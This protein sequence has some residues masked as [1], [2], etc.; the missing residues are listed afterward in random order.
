MIRS[1][2]A[3]ILCAAAL[4]C[5]REP[6]PPSGHLEMADRD[7]EA[8]VSAFVLQFPALSLTFADGSPEAKK[9]ADAAILVSPYDRES[10]AFGLTVRAPGKIGG[11]EKIRPL[12]PF[13][14]AGTRRSPTIPLA[15]NWYAL[16]Y[17]EENRQKAGIEIPADW[18]SL[19]VTSEKIKETGSVPVAL[20]AA[21]GRTLSYWYSYADM[22]LNGARSYRERLEGKR[23]YDDA[24]SVKALALV[25]EM[26]RSGVFSTGA[27]RKTPDEAWL[28]LLEGRAVF[29]LSDSSALDRIPP[30]RDIRCVAVP[31]KGSKKF[32]D[33]G[34]LSRTSSIALLSEKAEAASFVRAF[35]LAGA[36]GMTDGKKIIAAFADYSTISAKANPGPSILDAAVEVSPPLDQS[37]PPQFAYDS[38]RLFTDLARDPGKWTAQTFCARLE[39]LR[40]R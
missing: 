33:R 34:E 2:A 4:S 13:K 40:R 32:V 38:S 7:G 10:V 19:L 22:R 25:M 5:A 17:D 14:N 28:D 35:A 6:V 30:G 37:F 24:D 15:A 23:R 27:S 3:A 8:A 31:V 26:L 16:W 9:S 1:I 12:K 20:G 11:Q 29:C 39:E 21:Y 18:E 36:P